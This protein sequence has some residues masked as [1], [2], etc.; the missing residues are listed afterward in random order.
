MRRIENHGRH[1]APFP[2]PH[3]VQIPGRGGRR[4]RH[5][6]EQVE[7]GRRIEMDR[8]YDQPVGRIEQRLH[9]RLMLV[10]KIAQPP[11]RHRHVWDEQ[12]IDQRRDAV[13]AV[14]AGDDG[15]LLRTHLLSAA[16]QVAVRADP[17]CNLRPARRIGADDDAALR[18]RRAGLA[19]CLAGVRL[20]LTRRRVRHHIP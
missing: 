18:N 8:V 20:L 4:L 11:E 7:V 3:P 17:R 14:A 16:D 15:D 12:R 10:R 19:Q 5:P 6:A 9:V 13:D 2:E 1:G